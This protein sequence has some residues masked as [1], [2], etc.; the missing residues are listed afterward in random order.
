MFRG[1]E[2]LGGF[3]GFGFKV[4]GLAFRAEGEGTERAPT[5]DV[6]AAVFALFPRRRPLEDAVDADARAHRCPP[7][8]RRRAALSTSARRWVA[9]RRTPTWSME[10]V[11]AEAPAAA[12]ERW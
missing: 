10:P 12:F 5:F 3:R 1:F 8:P 4:Q 6:V 2:V 9:R 7:S 11:E